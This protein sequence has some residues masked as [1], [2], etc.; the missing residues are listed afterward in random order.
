MYINKTALFRRDVFV[1]IVSRGGTEAKPEVSADHSPLRFLC[2][3]DANRRAALPG[4]DLEAALHVVGDFGPFQKRAVAV[5]VLT[6]VSLSQNA[7]CVH[8][9]PSAPQ[10]RSSRLA[11]STRRRYVASSRGAFARQ[12][13]RFT[14]KTVS[15]E[16]T[17]PGALYRDRELYNM[18]LLINAENGGT[19]YKVFLHVLAGKMTISRTVVLTCQDTCRKNIISELSQQRT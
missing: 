18:S 15:S 4:M 8:Q 2:G 1:V 17:R 11:V 13:A 7:G 9:K 14:V 3:G 5:L 6:Q 12:R 19:S 10:R 16:V